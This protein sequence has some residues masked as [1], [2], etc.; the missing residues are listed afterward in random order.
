M[1]LGAGPTA[2]ARDI[3]APCYLRGGLFFVRISIGDGPPGLFLL[4]TGSAA[5]VLD[6]RFADAAKVRLGDPI[7]LLGGGGSTEARRAEEVDLSIGDSGRL[8]DDPL[9][10]DL[11]R[12]SQGMGLKL[13]G[14]LGDDVLRRFVV[15]LNYRT[16]TVNLSS[17]KAAPPPD[18]AHMRII[19]T[20]YVSASLEDQGQRRDAVFQIDTGSNTAI[21]FWAPFADA[22]FPEAPT[23]PGAGLGVAGRTR[24]Q[25]GRIDALIVA[26]RRIADPVANFA[27]QTRP[28]DAGLDYGGVIGGPAWEGLVLTLDY[29][30]QRVWVR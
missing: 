11:S 5:T 7:H 10:A 16:G 17:S 19:A 28:D 12:V 2:Q 8:R 24:S 3:A 1:A 4:D 27:D 20:P 29:A 6:A 30:D 14:I 23:V 18:A 22:A 13:D 9:V 25:L 15:V 26:G 21:A